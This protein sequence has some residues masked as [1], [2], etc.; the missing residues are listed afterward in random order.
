MNLIQTFK[1]LSQEKAPE[2]LAPEKLA[3]IEDLRAAYK[4][5]ANAGIDCTCEIGQAVTPLALEAVDKGEFVP[6]ANLGLKAG[7]VGTKALIDS[8]VDAGAYDRTLQSSHRNKCVI[9]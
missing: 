1:N 3:R 7:Q 5:S 8:A 9:L 4:P 2:E 6:I